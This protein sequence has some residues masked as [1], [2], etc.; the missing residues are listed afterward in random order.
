[1]VVN[2]SSSEDELTLLGPEAL[3][4]WEV[5]EDLLLVLR[6]SLFPFNTD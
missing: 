6:K 3:R 1:M 5:P 4:D 2:F